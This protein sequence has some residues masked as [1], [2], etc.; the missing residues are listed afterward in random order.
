MSG[1]A[2]LPVLTPADIE[3]EIVLNTARLNA[4]REA[5]WEKVIDAAEELTGRARSGCTGPVDVALARVIAEVYALPRVALPDGLHLT[6]HGD[7]L[8]DIRFPGRS[9]S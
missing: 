8:T 7:H 3:A 1:L 6:Y 5:A 2:T 9:E 4:I